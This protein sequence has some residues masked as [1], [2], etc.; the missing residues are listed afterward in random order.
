MCARTQ[1]RH[2]KKT[3]V[4]IVHIVHIALWQHFVRSK[5]IHRFDSFLLTLSKSHG[6]RFVWTICVTHTHNPSVN[7]FSWNTSL[8]CFT[9]G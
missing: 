7:K 2:Q 4:H 6:H 5:V 1:Q 3:V 9:P 8:L